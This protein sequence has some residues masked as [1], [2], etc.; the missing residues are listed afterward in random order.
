MATSK[1]KNEPGYFAIIPASVRYDKNI[2]PNAKL[3]YGEITALAKRDGYCWA[4]NSYF[5]GLYGVTAQAISIWIG[6]L[7]RRRYISVSIDKKHGNTRK[8]FVGNSIEE[9]NKQGESQPPYKADVNRLLEKLRKQGECIEKLRKQL[10]EKESQPPYKADV[11]SYK[12]DVNSYKADVKGPYIINSKNKKTEDQ[13]QEDSS[14]KVQPESFSAAADLKKL[15]LKITEEMQ[16]IGFFDCDCAGILQFF[17]G[18]SEEDIRKAFRIVQPQLPRLTKRPTGQVAN[19]LALGVKNMPEPASVAKAAPKQT[20]RF[21]GDP[22]AHQEERV[23]TQDL[24]V[25][26]GHPDFWQNF[27]LIMKRQDQYTGELLAQ[28]SFLDCNGACRIAARPDHLIILND[29]KP[30]IEGVLTK[31]Y[32]KKILVEFSN[33]EVL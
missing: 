2:S 14:P 29:V 20:H 13:Q 33:Q 17:K 5:A 26:P 1:S 11:N 8:I 27:C 30:L 10:K 4:R 16:E 9:H 7:K 3:L 15:S 23:S 22:P 19:M 6:Q 24:I 31:M 21:Y 32:N 18:H 28:S 12:A 25:P